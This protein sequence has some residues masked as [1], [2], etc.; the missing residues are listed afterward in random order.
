MNA[1]G[2][3][4]DLFLSSR[5]MVEEGC[6]GVMNAGREEALAL[7][8]RV[9]LP[10]RKDE[11]YKYT[12][13][14]DIFAPDY[15][16]NLK[17]VAFP[18]RPRDLF[19]CNVPGL[20]ARQGFVVN[21]MF[22]PSSDEPLWGKDGVAM[23]SLR[24]EEETLCRVIE[25]HYG[26]LSHREGDAVSALNTMLAQDGVL[27]Y[28]PRGVKAAAPIQL[29][30]VLRSEVDLMATRRVLVVAEEGSEAD[31]LLCDHSVDAHRFL[32]SQVVEVFMGKGS[33]LGLYE[34]EET[35]PLCSRMSHLYAAVGEKAGLTH[36]SVTLQGGTSRNTTHIML[37]GKG[38]TARSYGAVIGD[39][40]QHVDNNLRIEHRAEDGTSDILYK[41][42]LSSE[43][44]GAFAG[45][46]LVKEGAQHTA[47]QQT[48]ANLCTSP[49]AHAYS[50]PV[51]EIYA[52]DVQCNHGSSVG[53]LDE[54]ALFYMQQ[55]GLP[56]EE[57]YLLLQH[58]FLYDVIRRIPLSEL[59]ARLSHLIEMRFRGEL[60]HCGGCDMCGR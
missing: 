29:L 37:G 6:P 20:G 15:G 16:L 57:S 55:R 18:F 45:H 53:N 14:S 60:T 5:A 8:Q 38:A 56:K 34:L 42:V 17:R 21:D 22:V 51:L 32:S 23:C 26:R 24:T 25:R 9:G 19:R 36:C 58:A 35:S 28:L 48:N 49:S 43:A 40:R 12:S 33:R 27:I 30:N 13:P 4:I 44:V 2:Q 54:Q 50:Q 7:L 3:Y 41:Y 47:S 1:A 11:R 10:T 46:V 39:G 52:D 31:I 59:T